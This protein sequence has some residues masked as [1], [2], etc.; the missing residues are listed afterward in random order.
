MQTITWAALFQDGLLLVTI[1]LFPKIYQS[2]KFI[3]VAV[4]FLYLCCSSLFASLFIWCINE[5][6]KLIWGAEVLSA[7]IALS[8]FGAVGIG[9]AYYLWKFYPEIHKNLKRLVLLLIADIF[10]VGYFYGKY[11]HILA[12]IAFDLAV[13]S[14]IT[15]IFVCV[16]S[17]KERIESL[18][19]PVF[20]NKLSVSVLSLCIVAAALLGMI[21]LG[22]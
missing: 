22:L 11:A 1:L 3:D 14:S 17:L 7:L 2:F 12:P 10:L 9:F 16:L 20:V 6:Y 13:V 8:V 19:L 4:S 5:G 18:E 15:A 21:R